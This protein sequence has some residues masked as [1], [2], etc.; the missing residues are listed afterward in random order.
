[1]GGYLIAVQRREPGGQLDDIHGRHSGFQTLTEP[2]LDIIIE[3]LQSCIMD[4]KTLQLKMLERILSMALLQA[5]DDKEK[6]ANGR[7]R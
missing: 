6:S 7:H 4:A 3:R 2:S 1:M 5:N